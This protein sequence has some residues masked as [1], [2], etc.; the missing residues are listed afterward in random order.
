M[1]AWFVIQL[2][3]FVGQAPDLDG[4]IGIRGS[5]T[6]YEEGFSGLVKNIG[7]EGIHPPLMDLVNFVA[8]GLL[9]KDPR[10]LHL[11]SIVLFVIFAGTAE[12]LLAPFLPS[13]RQRV[14]GGVHD[15]DL[16]GARA[17]VVQRLARRA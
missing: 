10:S 3:R 1:L 11:I 7:N 9:G 4:M 8:F 2:G 14:A 6:I 16:P 17:D 13:A 12:R 5:L 15:R